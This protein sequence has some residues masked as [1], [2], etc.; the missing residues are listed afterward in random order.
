M[1]QLGSDYTPPLTA[2]EFKEEIITQYAA[3]ADGVG[4]DA[5][6][7][8]AVDAIWP[9]PEYYPHQRDAVIQIIKEL[10]VN[11]ADGVKL[12][13]PTGAGKSLIIYGVVA[14]LDD[15]AGRDSFITTPQN[16]LLDQI[17]TD[18]FIG[19]DV[20][21]LK[22]QSNYSC[23]HR[24]DRGASVDNAI[25][26]RQDDFQCEHKS[27]S[28]NN[29]GCPYYGR[30]HVA[31]QTA[32]FATNISYLMA[33]SMI[34][35]TIESRFDPRELLFIDECQ[36]IEDFALQFI[37]VVV[38]D[39]NV[40]VV[41]DQISDPPSDDIDE[42]CGWLRNEVQPTVQTQIDTYDVKQHLNE[43]EVDAL[44]KLQQFNRKV[45][46]L[47]DDVADN[48]WTVN[49]E[50]DDGWRVEFEPIHV[51]RFLD[52][53]L[54]SQANKFVLSSATIP[55]ASFESEIGVDEMDVATVE[56]PSTFDV[57]RRPIID[58]TVGSMKYA[59][60]DE[61]LPKVAQRIAD[62][63]DHHEHKRGFVH[64]H[65]YD[66]AEKIYNAMPY[67]AR[68]RA[69]VQRK[70]DRQQSLDDWLDADVDECGPSTNV[71]GQIFLSVSMVEGI[72]LDDWRARWQVVAKAA[73]PFAGDDAKRVNYRLNELNDWNW[74]FGKAAID[75]QQAIGRGMR[76]TDDYCYTYIVDE[77]A[78]DI[79]E[80]KQHLCE[81]YVLDAVGVDTADEL[82]NAMR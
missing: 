27:T 64:C 25:C 17:Q 5:C 43:N 63:A 59:D 2:D 55:K 44:E 82:P 31:Q 20:L 60:R 30:K 15:V 10:Y 4:F 13:A 29:G 76:G 14:V 23:V 36:S 81:Q 11:D 65:S 22:G 79:L 33:N 51:G 6:I 46:N 77:S 80:N 53:F 12:S 26:Q 54:W 34:P 66:I 19:N 40:P 52:S 45:R 8:A 3:D 56:V 42:L 38:S 69:R 16:S 62:I 78:M 68:E 48:H 61:T 28:H 41:Y 67:E 72:S 73:F 24:M 21:T 39:N 1:F 71:G 35:E 70:A 9:A 18:E 49:T 58:S 50:Y 7:G 47:L 32:E 75:L 57:H 37:S 74:Y